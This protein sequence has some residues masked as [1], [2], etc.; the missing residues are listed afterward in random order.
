MCLTRCF[1]QPRLP[2]ESI[3]PMCFA[4]F[5]WLV[6]QSTRSISTILGYFRI[7]TSWLPIRTQAGHITV[8]F[9]VCNLS[10]GLTGAWIPIFLFLKSLVWVSPD[11]ELTSGDETAGIVTGGSLLSRV[12]SGSLKGG[13]KQE[14][15]E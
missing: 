1:D 2:D 12:K 8:Y 11:D 14:P 3:S 9:A 7:Y 5:N 10:C 4:I 6:P 15:Q 13:M